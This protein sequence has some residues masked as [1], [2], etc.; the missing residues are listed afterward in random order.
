MHIG[1]CIFLWFFYKSLVAAYLSFHL[2]NPTH[3]FKSANFNINWL[4]RRWFGLSIGHLFPTSC[5]AYSTLELIF[6]AEDYEM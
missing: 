1:D 6:I 3:Q 2:A 5:L 4:A